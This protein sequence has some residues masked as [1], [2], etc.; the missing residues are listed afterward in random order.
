MNLLL[1]IGVGIIGSIVMEKLRVPAGAMIGA[2]IS[3]AL[4]NIF[5]GRAY[6][7]ALIKL[8]VQGV[9]GGLIGQRISMKDIRE[10]KDIIKPSIIFLLGILVI[11]FGMG[12]LSWKTTILD[13]PTSL[14]AFMP[15]GLTEVAVVSDELGADITQAT[16]LQLIRYLFAIIILPVVISR[17][18]RK[19]ERKPGVP[20]ENM[21]ACSVLDTASE[22]SKEIKNNKDEKRNTILTLIVASIGGITGYLLKVPAGILVFAMIFTAAYNIRTN[23]AYMPSYIRYAAQTLAGTIAGSAVSM[24]DIYN[25]KNIMVPGIFIIIQC[26]LINFLLGFLIYKAGGLD[27]TT[28]LFASIPAGVTDI[29]LIAS[30]FGGKAPKVTVF[31]LIRFV[32]V[33]S[34]FPALIRLFSNLFGT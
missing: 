13:L 23:R 19:K 32:G 22:E 11:C 1:T 8:L 6:S 26:L 12:F 14:V 7:P 16:T 34:I 4:F 31:Q 20:A 2:L 28:C 5:F 21:P 30:G 10:I 25:F 18:C 33:M 17:I 9:A 24:Q 3:T 29:A 27:I 15:G